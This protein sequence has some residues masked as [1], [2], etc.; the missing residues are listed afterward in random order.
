M[1]WYRTI[2]FI[3]TTTTTTKTIPNNKRTSDGI[4]TT[5]FK[6]Y[7]RAIVMKT[8]WYWYTDRQVDLW[9]RLKTEKWTHTATIT[10]S[11]T[12]EL[13]PSSGKK[14]TSSK[15]VLAQLEVTI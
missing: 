1:F 10:C 3:K 13:K 2:F 5:D 8:A 7:D 4:T 15:M 9:N 11:L 6:L 12:K 14:A